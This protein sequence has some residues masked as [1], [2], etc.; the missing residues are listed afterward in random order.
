VERRS[1]EI[2]VDNSP[3]RGCAWYGGD[4][5][6]LVSLTYRDGQSSYLRFIQSSDAILGIELFTPMLL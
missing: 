4:A 3:L 5:Q 1:G 2:G 6:S